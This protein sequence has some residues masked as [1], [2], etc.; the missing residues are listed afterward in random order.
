MT[1]AIIH[2]PEATA[3]LD[4]AAQDDFYPRMLGITA[5]GGPSRTLVLDRFKDVNNID[6]GLVADRV[7]EISLGYG[8]RR[9]TKQLE[10]VALLERNTSFD[11]GFYQDIAGD[12]NRV[13]EFLSWFG[14]LATEYISKGTDGIAKHDQVSKIGLELG[15]GVQSGCWKATGALDSVLRSIPGQLKGA[16]NVG[17]LKVF[18]EASESMI[19]Y[20]C[21]PLIDVLENGAKVNKDFLVIRRRR[22]LAD[23]SLDGVDA[24]IDLIKESWGLLV[25][26][27]ID[28]EDR[29]KILGDLRKDQADKTG[30]NSFEKS[31]KNNTSAATIAGH[32][33]F[34][35]LTQADQFEARNQSTTLIPIGAHAYAAVGTGLV[36]QND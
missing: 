33:Y 36:D 21:L 15:G 14:G 2:S 35:K 25:L 3:P 1:Q 9:H 6:P 23:L 11:A 18:D 4:H 7:G 19:S 31:G 24:K 20:R 22:A 28:D 27:Q 13:G 12:A 10:T 32:V 34:H 30:Y 26:S 8:V 16:T 29:R 17:K 5:D